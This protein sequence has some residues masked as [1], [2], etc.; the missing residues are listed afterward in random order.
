MSPEELSMHLQACDL[1]VQP[2][3]DGITARRTSA[4]CILANGVPMVTTRGALTE[5]IWTEQPTAALAPAE[6]LE[7]LV[8]CALRLLTD[9]SARTSLGRQGRHLY[10]AYFSLDQV[11]RRLNE[12]IGL[13]VDRRLPAA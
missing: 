5:G 4:M 1:C 12:P 8:A 7:V 2:Y 9:N 11:I 13:H 6:N 3:P 10:D